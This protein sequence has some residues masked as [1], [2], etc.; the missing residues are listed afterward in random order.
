M[1]ELNDLLVGLMIAV[2][3]GERMNGLGLSVFT[4][5][6]LRISFVFGTFIISFG[7]HLVA[8]DCRN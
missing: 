5:F 4:C 1:T 3:H 7:F 2:V 6:D 8:T